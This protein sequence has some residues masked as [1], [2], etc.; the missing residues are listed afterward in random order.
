M[1][2]IARGCLGHFAR[3]IPNDPVVS[4]GPRVKFIPQVRIDLTSKSMAD[5][6]TLVR[7]SKSTC[8]RELAGE[9]VLLQMDGGE[10]FGLDQTA[11]RIWQLIVE[12]GD[13]R[14]VESAMLAEFDVDRAVL[15]SDL[16]RVID[17]L[18]AKRLI[19]I[20]PGGEAAR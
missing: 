15:E 14:E 4:V 11:T 3:R 20:G 10:Y 9:T 18:A 2:R 5:A 7:V 6:K 12:K 17:E 19:E 13:L 16:A 8:Y 1:R